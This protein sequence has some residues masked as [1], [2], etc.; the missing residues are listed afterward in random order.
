MVDKWRH[1]V[2][3]ADFLPES[4]S[5][6]TLYQLTVYEFSIVFVYVKSQDEK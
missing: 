2:N 3:C 5:L 6:S 1:T 4:F